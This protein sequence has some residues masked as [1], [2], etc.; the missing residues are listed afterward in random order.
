[1]PRDKAIAY[2]I[3]HRVSVNQVLSVLEVRNESA[4]EQKQP[5]LAAPSA[6]PPGVLLSCRT[7]GMM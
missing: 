7:T 5:W 3:S 2:A 4:I 1:M 6:W